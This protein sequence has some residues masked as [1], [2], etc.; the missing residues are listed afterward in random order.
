MKSAAITI[1]FNEKKNEVLLIKRKDIP[2]FVLPGG[3]IEAFETAE[4]AAVRE[5]LEETGLTVKLIRKTGEY[6]PINKLSAETHVFEA[7]I[8]SGKLTTGEETREVQFF[9]LN[10]LPKPFFIIHQDF[11]NDALKNETVVKKPLSQVTY[12][13]LFLNLFKHP[14]L[15]LYALKARF[16]LKL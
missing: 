4:D 13:N 8:L 7:S 10:N 3:G 5:A 6:T 9:P 16:K 12:F 11:L 14:I 2:V 1:V 15:I